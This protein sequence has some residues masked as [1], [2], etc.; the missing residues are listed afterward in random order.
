MVD[1]ARQWIEERNNL[2]DFLIQQGHDIEKVQAELSSQH[3]NGFI[4]ALSEMGEILYQAEMRARGTRDVDLTG[5][6]LACARAQQDVVYSQLI[7]AMETPVEYMDVGNGRTIPFVDV[8]KGGLESM[9]RVWE[10]PEL[11]ALRD[12]VMQR[13]ARG[14]SKCVEVLSI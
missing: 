4:Y 2:K 10:E 7:Q 3:F 13:Y 14:V 8:A 6:F 12:Y 1:E 11:G 5:Q 9:N